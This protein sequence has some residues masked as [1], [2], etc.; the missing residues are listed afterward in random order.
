M[1]E[2]KP[3]V[4]PKDRPRPSSYTHQKPTVLILVAFFTVISLQWLW[5]LQQD[6]ENLISPSHTKKGFRWEDVCVGLLLLC[7]ALLIG[8]DHPFDE[9][10]I[11]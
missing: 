2:K 5:Q 9:S 11:S 3:S 10:R 6:T 1:A 4:V 7:C 8:A